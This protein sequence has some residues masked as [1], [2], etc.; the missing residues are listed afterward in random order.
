MFHLRK[1]PLLLGLRIIYLRSEVSLCTF[2]SLL[3]VSVCMLVSWFIVCSVLLVHL[4]VHVF[5]QSHYVSVC[6]VQ[7]RL[8][9]FY[10]FCLLACFVACGPGKQVLAK[11]LLLG[12][13]FFQGS[14]SLAP[15][16]LDVTFSKTVPF[17][18]SLFKRKYIS[19][20]QI[21]GKTLPYSFKRHYFVTAVE[22][23]DWL[24]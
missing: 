1:K 3:G 16:Y 4:Y 22:R 17:N 18:H 11:R 5:L 19:V 20:S 8:T 14:S 24:H 2:R 15:H 7:L 9:V 13:C 23:T 21:L 12:K 6:L 10:S